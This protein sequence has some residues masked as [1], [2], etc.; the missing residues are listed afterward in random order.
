MNILSGSWLKASSRSTFTSPSKDNL[1]RITDDLFDFG[2]V[3]LDK[4]QWQD[5]HCNDLLGFGNDSF[6]DF[7]KGTLPD[8]VFFLIL[9]F[10]V[11]Q[12]F[13]H[14]SFSKCFL[15]FNIFLM[16]LIFDI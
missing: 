6:V 8:K 15:S 12:Y 11:F 2:A 10:A 7:G 14:F 3:L 1:R 5:S 4:V 16:I 13:S 9:V